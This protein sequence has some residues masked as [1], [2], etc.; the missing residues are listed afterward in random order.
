[1][2]QIL[3]LV[4][5]IAEH[6]RSRCLRRPVLANDSGLFSSLSSHSVQNVGQNE[7]ESQ[8]T[9]K[10]AR[11]LTLAFIFCF[12]VF[13]QNPSLL[14]SFSPH[15]EVPPR[16]PSASE[17]VFRRRSSYPVATRRQV[18]VARVRQKQIYASFARKTLVSLRIDNHPAGSCTCLNLR[19]NNRTEASNCAAVRR[20]SPSKPI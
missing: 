13:L 11:C 6:P 2:L 9:E 7:Q 8:Q 15:V 5:I 18:S 12:F 19:Q 1:M 10:I 4:V 14:Y 3:H 16:S 17:R 20:A